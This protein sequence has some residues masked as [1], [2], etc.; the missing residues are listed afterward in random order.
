MMA[1]ARILVSGRVQGVAFRAAAQAEA[2]RLG[3]GGWVRNCD[4]GDVEA[5]AEGEKERVE[6]FIAFCR[7]GPRFARVSEVTVR[8][9][10]V[11]GELSTFDIRG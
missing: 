2:Y 1:R 6:H 4:D 5:L 3:I 10:E 9:E 7:H 11:R 8:F